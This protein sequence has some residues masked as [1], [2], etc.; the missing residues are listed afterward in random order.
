[1]VAELN[2]RRDPMVA[3]ALR[4]DGEGDSD[5]SEHHE[6]DNGH[7][8]RTG[9]EEDGDGDDRAELTPCAGPHEEPPEWPGE[10][11]GVAQHGQERAKC[12]RGE[13]D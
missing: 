11:A 4:D 7:E 2:K 9:A 10:L 12:G 6:R 1:M 8:L 3:Q 13:G 5:A